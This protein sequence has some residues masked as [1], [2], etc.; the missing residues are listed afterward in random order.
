MLVKKKTALE[1]IPL[2]A[3]E[4]LKLQNLRFVTYI[5]AL[6]TYLS[7]SLVALPAPCNILNLI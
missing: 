1:T 5:S 4:K 3:S 6:T 2:G 7:F